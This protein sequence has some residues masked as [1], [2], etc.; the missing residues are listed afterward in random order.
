MKKTRRVKVPGFEVLDVL[1]TG[2]MATVYR[3]VQTALQRQVAL[4]V[5]H[6]GVARDPDYRERFLREAR[7][8]ARLSHGNVVRA[9]EAGEHEGTY[10]FAMELV[11]GED[12]S[13]CLAR[14]GA[15]PEDEALDVAIEVARALAAAEEHGLVHR[16]VKPEN[17][18]L[19]HDGA[20]KLADL[21]LAK[22]QGDGSITAE[23]VTVGTVAFLSPEQ[24]R[25]AGDLDIRSDLWA[26]GAVL[27][28]MV[29]G[30]MPYGRGENAVLTME[31]IVQ[32]DPPG[33]E[34][35][36]AASP[37]TVAAVRRLMARARDERPATARDALALLEDAQARVG[38]VVVDGAGGVDADPRA[39]G[40]H[41]SGVRRARR[42][43]R[44]A[45]SAG[46][47]A[48]ARARGRPSSP[49]GILA[50]LAVALG[51]GVAAGAALRA[52]RSAEREATPASVR[53]V[54]SGAPPAAPRQ[55][56]GR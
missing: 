46:A 53:S 9:Y 29:T 1:G 20:V 38:E 43:R 12:L 24:C 2:A 37:A 44:R 35:H 28:T 41:A 11:E 42:A 18:L 5:L 22:A 4:K 10:W 21:G 36:A 49:L 14:R 52:E 17:I 56:G 15:L 54:S 39:D 30:D 7:A 40:P 32:E 33:L 3:A 23:G 16:D 47:W 25:G 34:G 13:E 45:G 48:S 26:L 50:P 31:R 27:F 55:G 8:A 6:R 19:G 51:V